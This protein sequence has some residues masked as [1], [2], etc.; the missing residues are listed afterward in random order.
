MG[1]FQWFWET[2]DP[3]GE[4]EL[5]TSRDSVT[6][7]RL[8]P[9]RP[10]LARTPGGPAVGAFDGQVVDTALSPPV[11]INRA[12]TMETLSFYYWGGPA[13]H[14]NRHLTHGRGIGMAQLRADGFCSLQARRFPGT[15]VTK[16][17][18][19]PGGTLSLNFSVLG[20]A[21]NGGVQTEVLHE[22]LSPVEG[23]AR[24]DADV[25]RGDGTRITQT[26]HGDARAIERVRG[27]RVCLKFYVDNA[28]L[29]SFRAVPEA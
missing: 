22:D 17:L 28:G 27:Q 11:R 29:F 9:R 5:M 13:M 20:G 25:M 26:W 14:G 4:M 1:L 18:T 23:L 7:Q 8:R 2:D 16:P 21:G 10:F 15:I 6:W 24:A 12:S 3:Y 19:W